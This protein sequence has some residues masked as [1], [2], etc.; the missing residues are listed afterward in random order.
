MPLVLCGP[1]FFQEISGEAVYARL[2]A[3]ALTKSIPETTVLSLSSESPDKRYLPAGDFR[4]GDI[5]KFWR[6]FIKFSGPVIFTRV[7]LWPLAWP[8]YLRKQPYVF[9]LHGVEAWRRFP[10]WARMIFRRACAFWSV[11]RY[12]AEKFLQANRLS[13]FWT[14][15]PPALDPYFKDPEETPLKEDYRYLITVA[16]LSPDAAY[17]GVDLVIKVLPG[18]L[19]DF[20]DLHYVVIGGGPLLRSYQELAAS[21]G[22]A[23]RVHFLGARRD[24]ARFLRAAEIFVL[25]SRGEGFGIVFLEAMFFRKPLIGASEGGIPEVVRDGENG[26]LVP[27]GD[28][29]AL[30]RALKTLLSQ[31]EEARRLGEAGYRLLEREYTFEQFRNRL[32]KELKRLVWV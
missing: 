24:V 17:K 31:K 1:G 11:S 5:F 19:R 20:P 15:L 26:L 30:T 6:Y 12:T 16:R 18:L 13:S 23:S 27:Y 7:T 29:E 2:L 25:V 28:L 14:L 21:L 32:Y 22:V 8:L 3:Y 4:S 9:V 10:P